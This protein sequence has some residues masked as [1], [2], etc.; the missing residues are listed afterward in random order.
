MNKLVTNKNIKGNILTAIVG[1][2]LMCNNDNLHFAV[3]MHLSKNE[4][5]NKIIYSAMRIFVKTGWRLFRMREWIY[6][7]QNVLMKLV[8]LTQSMNKKC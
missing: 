7:A 2:K 6:F 4:F 5:L 3:S 1:T 8:Q